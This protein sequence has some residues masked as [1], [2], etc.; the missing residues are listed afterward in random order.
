MQKSAIP[1]KLRQ[2][3]LVSVAACA[4]GWAQTGGAGANGGV[5]MAGN[6]VAAGSSVTA[7]ADTAVLH[8]ARG[9]EIRICPG[10]TVSVTPSQNGREVMLAM[11]TGS[12]EGHYQLQTSADALL[13]PDFRILF[14]GPGEFHYAV[15]VDRQ[16]NTCVRGLPGNTASAIVSELLG[17]R[18]YQ[19]RPAD[20]LV[21]RSG[22][23]DKVNT[24]V[25]I[26]CGCP[27]AL[28]QVLR[29]TGPQQA[30]KTTAEI[31]GLGT[32]A[33]PS[34]PET[35]SSERKAAP[36]KAIPSVSTNRSP[37][38]I[39]AGIASAPEGMKPSK[40]SA[41][42]VVGSESAAANLPPEASGTEPAAKSETAPLPPSRPDDVHVAVEAP[43][44]FRGD[45]PRMAPPPKAQELPAARKI[46][47]PQLEVK[48]EGPP[49]TA[50]A[51][52]RSAEAP[53]RAQRR[54]FLG[55]LGLDK[56]G[57]FFAKLFR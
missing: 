29:A 46:R 19:V 1:A 35:I 15:S 49:P 39:S 31:A 10:T 22:Q 20:Q 57:K 6:Q 14:P 38:Q 26:D 36:A 3:L 25:P 54:S 8:I 48:V 21:F 5:V 2:L 37:A 40:A 12:V 43:F 50:A 17:D 11:S 52:A 33:I 23:I 55:K 7:G 56:V 47:E 32:R 16:G 24:K 27:P 18:T 45:D 13:T 41:S 30:P 42:S 53:A 9:G 28:E 34:A 51:Q 4:A 44:V